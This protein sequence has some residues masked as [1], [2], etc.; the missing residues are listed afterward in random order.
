[1]EE[2]SKDEGADTARARQSRSLNHA[3]VEGRRGPSVDF[4]R[5]D[6]DKSYDLNQAL[7]GK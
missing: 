2:S 1:M 4:V 3:V 6:S 5:G 7:Q